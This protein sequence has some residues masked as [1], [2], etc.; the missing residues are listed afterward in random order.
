MAIYLDEDM[1]GSDANLI[2]YPHLSSCMGVTVLMSDSTLLGA[3]ITGIRTEAGVLAELATQ[4]AKLATAK[5]EHL[6]VAGHYHKH[7]AAQGKTVDQKAQAL[8]FHGPA[9]LFDTSTIK[10][11]DGT[12]VEV[13]SNGSG[14]KCS[15]LYK[16]DEKARGMYDRPAAGGANVAK[17]YDTPQMKAGKVHIPAGVRQVPLYTTGLTG[18]I[19]KLHT[20]S[21]A[22]QVKSFNIP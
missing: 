3:H 8:N 21:F 20:A 15:I 1:V 19:H 9:Y 13:V 14:H 10:P 11:K 22:H 2:A 4:I 5:M 18:P 16:R 12:Y 6:Y 17:Y 7:T